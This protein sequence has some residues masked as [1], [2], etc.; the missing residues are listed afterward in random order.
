MATVDVDGSSHLS[1]DSQPKSVGHGY[2]FAKEK[3]KRISLSLLRIHN[4]GKRIQGVTVA[5]QR[6]YKTDTQS[7]FG[8]HLEFESARQASLQK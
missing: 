7:T 5:Y 1:A 6:E 3:V 2:E 4:P 8:L